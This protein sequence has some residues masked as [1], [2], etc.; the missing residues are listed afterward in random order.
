MIQSCKNQDPKGRTPV[1]EP[2]KEKIQEVNE[3]S[4]TEVTILF[5]QGDTVQIIQSKRNSLISDGI[6]RIICKKTS[7]DHS[8]F[9]NGELIRQTIFRPDSI[10]I[11]NKDKVLLWYLKAA[12]DHLALVSPGSVI[13]LKAEATEDILRLQKNGSVLCAGK[14][15]SA[16]SRYSFSC[17]NRT[18]QVD[19][20][21]FHPGFG[22]CG[23]TTISRIDIELALNEL[24]LIYGPAI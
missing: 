8:Y 10:E 20:P 24:V 3:S 21:F 12:K 18:I 11:Y 9:L 23:S 6:N 22:L 2:P 15:N 1:Y 4:N 13:E 19:A 14:F 7:L 17:E 16:I 5:G